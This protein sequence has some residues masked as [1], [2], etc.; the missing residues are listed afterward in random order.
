MKVEIY[1]CTHSGTIET[2]EL[3]VAEIPAYVELVKSHGFED[4]NGEEYKFNGAKV[5][6]GGFVVYVERA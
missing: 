4:S 3:P 5:C 6:E 2:V 1:N